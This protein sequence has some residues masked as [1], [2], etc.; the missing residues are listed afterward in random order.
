MTYTLRDA[1]IPTVA[2][3]W[4]GWKDSGMAI[5]NNVDEN[6]SL[7]KF[8]SDEEGAVA[9]AFAIKSGL[10]RIL[11]GK[12]NYQAYT[13]Q[14]DML[15]SKVELSDSWKKQMKSM[16]ITTHTQISFSDLEITGKS[17]ELLSEVEKDVLLCWEI[18]WMYLL[19]KQTVRIFFMEVIL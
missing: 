18:F 15:E 19:S 8:M 10:S 1:G 7:F 5:D 9:M 11:I 17:I 14:A 4:T 12:I 16:G 2:I 3:D 13:A 6:K